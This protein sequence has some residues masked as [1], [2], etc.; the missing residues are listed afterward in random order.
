MISVTIDSALMPGSKTPKPPARPDPLLAGMPAADVLLP[1]RRTSRDR[2]AREQAAGL[3][4]GGVVLRVPGGEE[5]QA[6]FPRRS[7]PGR[8][9]R[10]SVAAGGFSSITC[11]PAASAS[12]AIGWRTCG[13]VQIATASRSGT[14]GH[15]ARQ[16]SGTRR[17]PTFSPRWL[18]TAASRK[19]GLLAMTGRCWSCGDLAEPDDADAMLSQIGTRHLVLRDAKERT[20]AGQA[21]DSASDMQIADLIARPIGCG[22]RFSP[23]KGEAVRGAD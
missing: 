13:G 7:A 20:R 3:V 22:A 5:D 8:R 17:A 23:A 6:V 9:A 12:R 10:E 16:D 4:H 15:T 18:E 21:S 11:L 19:A 2:L 1:G 14:R